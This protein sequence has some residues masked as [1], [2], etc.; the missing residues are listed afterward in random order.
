M[1][2]YRCICFRNKCTIGG[3]ANTLISVLT[4]TTPFLIILCKD[5]VFSRG[6]WMPNVLWDDN[7]S[8]D[9]IKKHRKQKST[10]IKFFVL[11]MFN[12][13]GYFLFFFLPSSK[14]NNKGACC[15]LLAVLCLLRLRSK[16][17]YVS[18]YLFLQASDHVFL[19]K[20]AWNE[21]MMHLSAAMAVFQYDTFCS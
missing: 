19:C 7:T 18:I 13:Y 5:T 11:H 20:W 10:W 17:I 14:N 8:S 3:T 2:I 9:N 1:S 6:C 15:C 16:C 21:L 12:I 4:Y